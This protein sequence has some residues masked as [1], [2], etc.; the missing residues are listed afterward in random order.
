MTYRSKL[1]P[2]HWTRVYTGE[3]LHRTLI[4]PFLRWAAVFVKHEYAYQV[5]SEGLIYWCFE[6]PKEAMLFKLTWL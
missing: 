2:D 3:P 6:D 1:A 5:D 4:G